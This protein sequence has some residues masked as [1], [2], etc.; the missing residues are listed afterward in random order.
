M[1]SHPSVPAAAILL[2]IAT[3]GIGVSEESIVAT[4]AATDTPPLERVVTLHAEGMTLRDALAEV[5]RQAG[6]PLELDEEAMAAAEFDLDAPVTVAIE[7]ES[8]DEAQAQLIQRVRGRRLIGV[9]REVRDGK[10]VFTTVA[11]NQTRSEAHVKKH[12]PDWMKPLYR[13]GLVAEVD[14]DGNIVKVTAGEV[15]TDELLTQLVTLPQL[16]ELTLGN[17]D[18]LTADGIAHLGE[19]TALETLGL[20]SVNIDGNGLGNEIIRSIAGL[21]K[22]TDLSIGECGTTDAGVRL[23]EGMPQLER[24]RLEQEGRLTDAALTS[25]G[26][27]TG[28][29]RLDLSSRVGTQ[30]YG[31]MRFSADAIRQLAGLQ[32]LEEFYLSG[33]D[34]PPD[35]LIFDRLK[36]LSLGGP[37][38]NDDC[39]ERIAACS[40]LEFLSLDFTNM[41]DA[42]L[43]RIAALP[44][45]RRLDIDSYRITDDGIAHLK[46]LKQLQSLNLR[47]SQLSDASLAHVAEIETLTRLNLNGSG[48]PGS[49]M[50]EVF[51]VSGL[52][53]LKALPKLRT[54]WLHNLRSPVGFLGLQDL[55]QLR[56]LTMS[57]CN[58]EAEEVGALE[59]AMPNTMISASSGAGLIRLRK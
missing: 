34:V 12:L 5:C 20:D 28:L 38:V 56:V 40:R 9:I 50:G 27:L 33:H 26:K 42:G 15:V 59:D 47:A 29:R 2:A 51:T 11:A 24:L 23:L 54:L 21:K 30:H 52:A 57:M 55:T 45:L 31:W 13:H 44:S 4:D 37:G 58:I 48:R 32:N 10:L 14:D 6:I 3:A 7:Q 49:F 25:I 46:N 22:L 53:Q 1:Y 36:S 41:T 35:A 16:R 43:Q 39:A 17:T 19:M 8:L 18:K